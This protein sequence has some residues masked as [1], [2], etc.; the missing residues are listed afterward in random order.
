MVFA[1]ECPVSAVGACSPGVAP[2]GVNAS[3]P[4]ITDCNRVRYAAATEAAQRL[5]APHPN[6]ETCGDAEARAPMRSASRRRSG[7][8]SARRLYRQPESGPGRDSQS[9]PTAVTCTRRQGYRRT[10]R[11]QPGLCSGCAPRNR[12]GTIRRSHSRPRTCPWPLG[13]AETGAPASRVMTP[14]SVARIL[15]LPVHAYRQLLSPVLPACC[16]YT[17]TCSAYALEALR[18]HGAL[19]G[20]WLTLRRLTR[21]HPWAGSG[22]DPVPANPTYTHPSKQ[23]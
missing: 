4:D 9:R 11:R 2:K 7:I 3:P 21:C 22:Y 6:R 10:S 1:R 20:G 18:R 15:R 19:R 16:R 14:I 17:P 8:P 12:G 13:S 23:R 5:R